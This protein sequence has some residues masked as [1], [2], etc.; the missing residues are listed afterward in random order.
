MSA[1]PVEVINV[2]PPAPLRS[3]DPREVP[4]SSIDTSLAAVA[5]DQ[6]GVGALRARFAT[7]PAWTPELRREPQMSD[8]PPAQAAVLVPIVT[9]E[10]PTVLLTERTAHLTHHSGQVA[11]PGGR[12]DPED[13]N[14]SA[15]ALREAWEEVGLSAEYIEV[16]GTLPTYTTIT[17]FIVTPVVALVRPD[18]ELAIN[19]HEVAE[20]FEVPLAFL[21]NPANHRRHT[22]TD[23]DRRSREW[24]SMPY[25]DGPNERFVWGAT[26][27]MLRNLYRFLSA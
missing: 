5:F 9:R 3:F 16:L 26:A 14:I 18:F 15:A 19:P 7:P 23:D 22:M 2:V 25:Q 24:L 8:R 13:A 10:Q 1:T 6:L 17:S 12:V 11:F 20:A 27:G 21:M 4:V